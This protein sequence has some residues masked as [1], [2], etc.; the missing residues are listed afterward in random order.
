MNPW[1]EPT[2]E[3]INNAL[4]QQKLHHGLLLHGLSGIGKSGFAEQLAER[5]LCLSPK[6]GQACHQCKSCLLNRAAT[7][8][9]K[10][11]INGDGKAIG[12]EQIRAITPF[13]QTSSALNHHKVVVIEMAEQMTLASANALLKTLEEPA[14]GR[15]IILVVND[16]SR[17][18]ATVLSRCLMFNVVVSKSQGHAFLNE[19]GINADEPAFDT[20]INQ[21]LKLCELLAQDGLVELKWLFQCASDLIAQ[22]HTAMNVIETQKKLLDVVQSDPS[23]ID[24][25]SNYLLFF[26]SQIQQNQTISLHDY[27]T[28]IKIVK[29][30]VFHA[31]TI[32]GV[33]L[34]LLCQSLL[35]KLK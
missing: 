30:F 16:L 27:Q 22:N 12:I 11:L 7:H 21:P 34:A 17:L 18:P 32:N 3:Q 14:A 5:L 9:D 20:L 13:C 25:F 29:D 4:T 26:L 19:Q 1:F 8:P 10:L 23:Y 2:F 31:K 28:R 15:F 33:N 24:I 6:H 35:I